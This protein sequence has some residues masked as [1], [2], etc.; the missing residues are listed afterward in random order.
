MQ[1]KRDKST[2]DIF[3]GQRPVG[4]PR[5]HQSNAAK[6]RLYRQRKK[7]LMPCTTK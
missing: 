5:L 4:R 2:I 1:D 6:Q 7:G 3:T